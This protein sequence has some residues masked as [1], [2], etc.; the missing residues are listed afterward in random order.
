MSTV[1]HWR[2]DTLYTVHKGEPYRLA[3]SHLGLVEQFPIFAQRRVLPAS[4]RHE[5]H[6]AQERE[7][8]RMVAYAPPQ[9]IC[10]YPN[11][12]DRMR[13]VYEASFLT[14]G[15]GLWKVKLQPSILNDHLPEAPVTHS[16]PFLDA[17]AANQR[18]AQH[19]D[20]SPNK[21]D[22]DRGIHLMAENWSFFDQLLFSQGQGAGSQRSFSEVD[23]G[24]Q[25]GALDLL[26]L[27]NDKR[28]RIFEFGNGAKSKQVT[29][30]AQGVRRIH[31]LFHDGPPLPAD[32][33][34]RYIVRYHYQPEYNELTVLKAFLG[35]DDEETV[36]QYAA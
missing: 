19:M 26:T 12:P 21:Q 15:Q 3:P 9:L 5:Q 33:I 17:L 34:L 8:Y 22:H 11:I 27:G 31:Q 23:L 36:F 4:F 16:R 35:N 7:T 32:S 29:H 13:L 6:I 30:H 25:H 2:T 20:M 1:E 28:L 10:E 24:R 18:W 14:A